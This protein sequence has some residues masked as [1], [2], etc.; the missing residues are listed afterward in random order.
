[1]NYDSE[2]AQDHAFYAVAEVSRVLRE[3][4]HNRQEFTVAVE[5]GDVEDAPLDGKYAAGH[6][7]GG[8][9]IRISV[10]PCPP[11]TPP[12]NEVTPDSSPASAVADKFHDLASRW[13]RET[14]F[15]SSRTKMVDH[16][17]YQE[18]IGMGPAVLPL[19]LGELRTDPRYW[20]PALHAITGEDPVPAEDRGIVRKMADAWLQWG[21]AHG[22]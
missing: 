13:K 5:A 6:L 14:R 11:S 1:M 18:I 16:P 3:A 10:K 9:E 2:R 17:T 12:K 4:I 21:K 8:C 19:I 20:F 15:C 7:D 22:F